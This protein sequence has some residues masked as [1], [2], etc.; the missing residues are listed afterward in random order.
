MSIVALL[1]YFGVMEPSGPE[2]SAEDRRRRD[3]R[4]PRIAIQAY[5]KSAFYY[6]FNSGDDQ[7]LLN[8]CGVDHKVFRQLLQLF[9]PTFESY[10]P[11][12]RTGRIR[13][14]RRKPSGKP[15]GRKR[16][17]DAL[18]CLGL[19]LYWF[20]TRGSCARAI[21]WAFGLTSTPTYM[22]LRFSRRILLYVLQ[23]EPSAKVIEPTRDELETY[24]NA[25]G[26]KY[27]ILAEE[28]V[29]G[30][31][32]GL[33]IPLQSSSIYGVQNQYYNGWTGGTYVNCV[34]VFSPDGRIRICMLNCPGSWH[35][36]VMI[37]A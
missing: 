14:I 8:C 32:D 4:T 19:L 20:R 30:A 5:R 24:I 10:V 36:S 27:P 16:G 3:K 17:I 26:S 13:P 18:G 21:S 25:I 34:F 35:D 37:L 9:Q 22:W 29:W 12:H 28:K 7:A 31:A 1:Y 11:C 33:K 23:E 6:M 2:L 15:I